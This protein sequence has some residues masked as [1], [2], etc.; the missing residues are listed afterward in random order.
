M[1]AWAIALIVCSVL[2]IDVI[3][4][5]SVFHAV[6]HAWNAMLR[7]YPP[8]EPAPDAV[9]RNF[10]SLKMGFYNFGFSV[11]LAV[12]DRFLHLSP[13][14]IIRWAGCRPGSVPWEKVTPL[15]PR[16]FRGYAVRI[17]RQTLTGPRWALGL[18]S[19][20]NNDAACGRVD[21]RSS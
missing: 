5:R 15:G 12:D 2:A 9:R 7:E 6:A 21:T 1:P 16:L 10:Q 18:A 20:P 17:G 3:I 14:W 8:V 4:V 11:H 13:A 19:P